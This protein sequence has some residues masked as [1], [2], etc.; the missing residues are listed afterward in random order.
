MMM[1][2]VVV[3]KRMMKL[4]VPTPSCFAHFDRSPAKHS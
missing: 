2:V 1:L 3:V 4:K